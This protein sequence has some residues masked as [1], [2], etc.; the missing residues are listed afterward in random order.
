MSIDVP[1]SE[2][3]PPLSVPS[4][5]SKGTLPSAFRKPRSE[6]VGDRPKVTGLRG[7]GGSRTG[8]HIRSCSREPAP[9]PGTFWQSNSIYCLR[10]QQETE[11]LHG[12]QA[13]KLPGGPGF[14]LRKPFLVGRAFEI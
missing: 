10:V 7:S 4:A 5:T 13:C 1:S 8:V 3:K 14:I 12:L 11:H 9:G 6:R 2:H